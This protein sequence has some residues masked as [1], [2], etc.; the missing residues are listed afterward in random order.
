MPPFPSGAELQ[1]RAMLALP[2]PALSEIEGAL[3]RIDPRNALNMTV[4]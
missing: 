1:V 2:M 3:R 4:L